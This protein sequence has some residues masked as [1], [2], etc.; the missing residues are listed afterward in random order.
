MLLTFSLKRSLKYLSLSARTIVMTPIVFHLV[1]HDN[2]I[3]SMPPEFRGT[4]PQPPQ[5]VIQKLNSPREEKIDCKNYFHSGIQIKEE[6]NRKGSGEPRVAFCLSPKEDEEKDK[7]Y[8]V[9]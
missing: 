9:N 4:L 2:T 3:E 7:L 6:A 8:K 5:K 1:R